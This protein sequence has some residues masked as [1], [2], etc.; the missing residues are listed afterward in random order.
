M[1]S[2]TGDKKVEEKLKESLQNQTSA[3]REEHLNQTILL[4]QTEF[5]RQHQ[6]SQRPR[7]TTG[8][9]I[10]REL[11]YTGRYM[12]RWQALWV[13]GVLTG[14]EILFGGNFFGFF[15]ARHIPFGLCCIAIASVW[16]FLP[17]LYRSARYKMREIE[18]TARFSVGKRLVIQLGIMAGVQT[19]LLLC[20]YVTARRR[21]QILSPGSAVYLVM[22]YLISLSVLV[23]CLRYLS[24]GR[25]KIYF[26]ALCG[27]GLCV[28]IALRKFMQPALGQQFLLV[29]TFAGVVLILFLGWQML[30]IWKDG[31][32]LKWA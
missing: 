15:K 29:W 26:T 20:L 11:Y 22:P 13:L 31:Y 3:V 27:F 24:F 16:S 14:A 7:I 10:L 2:N 5:R 19:L 4:A 1:G 21:F 32:A 12:W 30:R 28:L 8:Q 23:C 9:Y 18:G 25:L 6:K 17:F